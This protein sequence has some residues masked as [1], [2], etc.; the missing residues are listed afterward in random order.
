MGS[1]GGAGAAVAAEAAKS[2]GQPSSLLATLRYG[3]ANLLLLLGAAALII[4]GWAPWVVLALA[5][6]FGSFADEVS[7]DD[8][9]SLKESR[10]AFCTLN[11]YLSLP[12]VTLLA[13]LLVRFAAASPSLFEQPVEMIGAL[14][15]TGYL[16]ALVGATVAH[17]LTHRSSRLA[18]LSA[19]LLLGFT[20]NASFVIYHIYTHHRQV[21]TYDDA[22]TARRGERLR[23]FMARTL[24]QQFVQ[25]ARFEAARLKRKGLSPYSWRNE[26]ILAH[27]VPLAILVLAWIAG[28]WNG[29]IA[30]FLAGLIGRSFHELIN[31]VQHYGLV[32]VENS[33][34]RPHHSWDCYRT[35]S[36]VLHYNLPRHSDHHMFAT[37]AFWQL[38]THQDAPTLP[39]GYQTMAFIALTPPLW[40]HIMRKLLVDWDERFASEAERQVV[41]ERGWEGIA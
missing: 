10:C 33:P 26:L 9:T 28:G 15:L 40:R 39:Y 5:L 16:F 27:L 38:N 18:K 21:G 24:T 4:G 20:G 6:V 13:F 1:A 29:V 23:T 14:W 22:A 25:A 3:S 31:Y 8:D 17:E 35:L 36:N 19:Y 11:L 30:I 7:G 41:R 32:R 12:L 37:K 2:G 34:I